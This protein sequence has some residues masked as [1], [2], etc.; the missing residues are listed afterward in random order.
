[1]GQ[2]TSIYDE[3]KSYK[4]Y[5][6]YVTKEL[7]QLDMIMEGNPPDGVYEY[8]QSEENRQKEQTWITVKSVA[9]YAMYSFI[10][11]F[12]ILFIVG[13]IKAIR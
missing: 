7:E 2:I 11:L 1:M 12:V 8:V 4:D 6:T 9:K 10:G 13:R 5:S 3:F